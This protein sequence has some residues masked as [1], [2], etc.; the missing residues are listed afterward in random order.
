METN[1]NFFQIILST[2]VEQDLRLPPL[3]EEASLHS[4]GCLPGFSY[5]R[6][7]NDSLREL[8]KTYFSKDVV[9]A[10]DSLVPLAYK[11]DLGRYCLL[12]QYGGWY[13]DISLKIVNN[14]EIY[15]RMLG[16]LLGKALLH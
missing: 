16:R 7:N 13:A 8:I 1:K 5:K 2:N 3:L 15:Y 12:Y 6:W 11:S 10:Y 4:Q 9:D 14:E